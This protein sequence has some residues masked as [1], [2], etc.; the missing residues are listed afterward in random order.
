MIA[1]IPEAAGATLL[2]APSGT[3]SPA[4][5]GPFRASPPGSGHAPLSRRAGERFRASGRALEGLVRRPPC[6]SRTPCGRMFTGH[7]RSFRRE[8]TGALGKIGEQWNRADGS[9][10]VRPVRHPARESCG[11][12]RAALGWQEPSTAREPTRRAHLARAEGS[13]NC[14]RRRRKTHGDARLERPHPTEPTRS[15]RSRRR[16]SSRTELRPRALRGLAERTG[17]LRPGTSRSIRDRSTLPMEEVPAPTDP[18][19]ALREQR[20]PRPR[21]AKHLQIR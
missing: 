12:T 20:V 10:R 18:R 11:G 4:P 3:P 9:S 8:A 1:S 15:P 21:R 17:P 6:G 2:A 16:S 14:S 5:A 7:P 19:A 13:P